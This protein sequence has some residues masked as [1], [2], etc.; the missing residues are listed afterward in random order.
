MPSK[1]LT[2]DMSSLHIHIHNLVTAHGRTEDKSLLC[3]E[4][5]EAIPTSLLSIMNKCKVMANVGDLYKCF[6]I[7]IMLH[8]FARVFRNG[9]R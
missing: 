6:I 7:E 5:C 9:I 8:Y 3:G 2:C 1:T 4:S